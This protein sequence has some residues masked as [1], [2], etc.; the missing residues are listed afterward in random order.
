MSSLTPGD[1]ADDLQINW[2]AGRSRVTRLL[3][4]ACA[5]FAEETA[6]LLSNEAGVE[7]PGRA[8]LGRYMDAVAA[9]IFEERVHGGPSLPR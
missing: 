4:F 2:G 5:A 6:V 8:A 9:A 1:V 7:D 3:L